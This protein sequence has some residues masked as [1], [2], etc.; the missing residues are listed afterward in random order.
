MADLFNALS[1]GVRREIISLLKE[2][3]MT[4]GEIADRLNVTKPTLS[5]HFNVLKSADLVISERNGT[6]I[7]YSLNTTV[8]EELLASLVGLLS[9]TDKNER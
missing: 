5:G 9:N 8:A 3:D 4:A 1:S 7:T 6:T 2:R